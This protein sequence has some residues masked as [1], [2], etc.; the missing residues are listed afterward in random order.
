MCASLSI[1]KNAFQEKTSIL[2][3]GSKVSMVMTSIHTQDKLARNL[4]F[5]VSQQPFQN[6]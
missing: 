3:E 2:S 6:G 1:P 5:I 4:E